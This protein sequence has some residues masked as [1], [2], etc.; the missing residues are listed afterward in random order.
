[1]DLNYGFIISLISLFISFYLLFLEFWRHRQKLYMAIMH[2]VLIDGLNETLYF[3]L[4]L[5]FVNQASVSK[6]IYQIHFQPLAG[7]QIS[8]VPGEPNFEL[9][10]VTFRPFQGGKAACF[11][12]D[13]VYSLPLDIEPNHSKSV[14]L[15]LAVHPI[16]FSR[17]ESSRELVRTQV[18]FLVAV[19]HKNHTVARVALLIP[20]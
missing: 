16:S 11:Q 17:Y 14:Y 10:T 3:A 2:Y 20:L 5:A 6:T 19:D 18:G 4:N 9:K 8:E 13:D 15:A 12:L 7:Y 1:M